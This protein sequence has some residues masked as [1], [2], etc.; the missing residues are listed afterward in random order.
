MQLTQFTDYSFRILIYLS[1]QHG[2]LCTINEITEL[3]NVS[4]Q[5]MIKVAHNLVK[6]G[7]VK[8]I[9][10]RNGGIKLNMQLQEINI[11]KLIRQTEPNFDLV[12]C[13]NKSHNQ[14]K[15]TNSCQLKHA[16]YHAKNAFLNVLDQYTLADF[17]R[18]PIAKNIQ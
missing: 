12:E 18:T 17:A 7:Y 6:L 10:G 16:L 9:Q 11:G 15:I 1:T 3:H 14:C 4:K 8:G 2:K 13:F 5:H